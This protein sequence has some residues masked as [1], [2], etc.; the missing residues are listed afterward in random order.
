MHTK[1]RSENLNETTLGSWV[2][3]P[4][5]AWMSVCVYSVCVVLCVGTGLAAR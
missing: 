4:L 3:N 5:M 1:F 2:R